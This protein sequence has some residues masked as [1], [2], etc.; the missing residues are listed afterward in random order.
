MAAPY[1]TFADVA[2]YLG[3]T[4]S[5]GQETECTTLLTAA[6]AEVERRCRQAWNLDPILDERYWLKQD[7]L[8][9]LS[10]PVTS[11]QA[12]RI[13]TPRPGDTWLTL[14]AGSDYELIDTNEGLVSFAYGYH[15]RHVM[16]GVDYTPNRPVPSDVA[17][18]TVLI[19]AA[20]IYRSLNSD[21]LGITKAQLESA[22]QIA[23]TEEGIALSIPPR[24]LEIIAHH[25][26]VV[27]V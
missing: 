17:L 18:A 1:A 11:V 13:R 7:W 9:L 2:S 16:A 26:R 21:R 27:V 20:S 22:V 4:L 10:N 19:G 23:Y 6:Q 25:T 14:N 3:V 15:G 5:A 12:I 24:A 8:N